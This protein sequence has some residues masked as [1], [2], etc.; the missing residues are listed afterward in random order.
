MTKFIIIGS[1][2][3]VQQDVVPV[4]NS[5]GLSSKDIKIYAR[6][7]KEIFVRNHKYRVSKIEELSYIP[8][9]TYVYIAV[10][11][12]NLKITITNILRINNS[13]TLLVDTPINDS[14]ILEEF[15]NSKI[16]VSEDSKYLGFLLKQN[17]KFYKLNF[18]F[19]Y[20]SA[21]AYHGI[22]F[23]ESI[24]SN[25]FFSFSVLGFYFMFCSK[26][27]AVIFGKRDYE[28]GNII[29]NF[30][31]LNFPKLSNDDISLIG[32]LSNWDKVSYRFLDLKRIGLKEMIKDVLNNTTTD[33]VS[34]QEA[35]SHFNRA[36]KINR[37]SINLFLKRI[38]KYFI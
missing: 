11:T 13:T 5:I 22:A 17:I 16:W 19:F 24:L 9:K 7:N 23:I 21:F 4:L 6:R 36:R 34:L 2:R 28:K 30:K 37:Y 3:R 35:Y 38:Y 31:R 8:D 33:L 25:C 20:K 27:I 29:L 14:S 26:G 18:M 32:G 15:T 1:G 12:N 10:P